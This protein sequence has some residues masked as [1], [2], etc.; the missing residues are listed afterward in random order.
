MVLGQINT[1]ISVLSDAEVHFTAEFLDQQQLAAALTT[2]L[3]LASYFV[4]A[5]ADL[6]RAAR[7]LAISH[8]AILQAFDEAFDH[9]FTRSEPFRQAMYT[10]GG[11]GEQLTLAPPAEPT[12]PP[13]P[14]TTP[15]GTAPGDPD[16]GIPR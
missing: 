8:F 6:N 3:H 11:A 10:L 7:T 16:T 2:C 5:P 4:S 12:G 14:P 9:T 15:P 13:A 1:F